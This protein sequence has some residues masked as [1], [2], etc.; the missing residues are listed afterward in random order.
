ML[1]T[2]EYYL[3]RLP[4]QYNGFVLRMQWEILF[5][6]EGQWHVAYWELG[7]VDEIR[8]EGFADRDLLLA[9]KKLYEWAK[10]D[11]HVRGSL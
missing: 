9:V 2:I 3:E 6:K 7:Y 11:E 10:K 5:K 4:Q 1:H 8:G